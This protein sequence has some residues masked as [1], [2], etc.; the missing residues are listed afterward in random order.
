MQIQ[1]NG[2]LRELVPPGTLG[3][4][5]G[6]L[7]VVAGRVAVMVNDRVIRRS[8]RD[9]FE[10]KAGDRVEILAFFGGG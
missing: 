8:E 7:G 3:Q 9:G 4:L 2:E 1:V 10:L 5:L 6:E